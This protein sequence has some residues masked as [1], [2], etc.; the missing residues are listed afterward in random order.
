M[1]EVAYLLADLGRQ[2]ECIGIVGGDKMRV[3]EFFGYPEHVLLA[4]LGLPDPV[5]ELGKTAF[6]VIGREY[7]QIAEAERPQVFGKEDRQGER[8]FARGAAGVPYADFL[9][10]GHCGQRSR[11]DCFQGIGIPEKRGV[12]HQ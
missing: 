3:P 9:L 11:D 7:V 10:L 5:F 1:L 6:F 4:V 12:G 8:F 2:P